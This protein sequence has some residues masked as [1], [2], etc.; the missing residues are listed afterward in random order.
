METEIQRDKD[1]RKACAEVMDIL[2]QHQ[3][4]LTFHEIFIKS[5]CYL[6]DVVS[7]MIAMGELGMLE[8]AIIGGTV[9]YRF[10]RDKN[11]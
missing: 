3:Y 9:F 11:E 8:E 5:T 2:N 1:R 7:T 6:E 10:K 4:G